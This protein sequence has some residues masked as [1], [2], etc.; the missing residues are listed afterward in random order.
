MGKGQRDWKYEAKSWF[1]LYCQKCDRANQV[2]GEESVAEQHTLGPPMPASLLALHFKWCYDLF[3]FNH[4][5]IICIRLR[6]MRRRAH[7]VQR[8]M[9]CLYHTL[10]PSQARK[11]RLWETAVQYCVVRMTGALHSYMHSGGISPRTEEALAVD[12][13]WRGRATFLWRGGPC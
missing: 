13:C 8:S 1:H 7:S 12:G 10:S 11:R 4:L 2:Q 6:L 3:T 9:I 5:L